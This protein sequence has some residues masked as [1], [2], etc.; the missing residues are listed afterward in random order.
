M[1]VMV[2]KP[3]PD[4]KVECWMRG[5]PGPKRISL[6][7]YRGEWVVLFFY[8]RDF[9]YL[10]P[11]EITAFAALQSE[12]HKAGAMIL[13]ASTD[14]YFSHAT[15]FTQD[16]RLK[17]VR[18]PV[19]ADTSHRLSE[20]FG[21]LLDDGSALRGTFI[22]DPD[23]IIRHMSVNDLDVARNVPEVLRALLALQSGELC[24][25]GWEPGQGNNARYNEWLAKVFPRLKK[26]VLADATR[27]LKPAIYE[28]GDIIIRQ[29]AKAD[30]FYIIVAGE[31]SVIYRTSRGDEVELARL[32]PGEVFGEMGI[33]TE[34][35]RTADLRANTAVSLLALEWDDF[36]G[37]IEQS[38][39][40]AKDFMDIVEQRRSALPG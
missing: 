31:V 11:T 21:V 28:A 37:L 32:G 39:P 12:F 23:G 36:K 33:L 29:G 1:S 7:Q 9:T 13:A 14:S 35:R 25:A 16:E 19:I 20:T 5:A 4:V 24:P 8:P 40:T 30:R 2:G 18:F 15:W 6:S 26:S 17:D 34:T 27:R 38:D 10:C 3:A 22:I